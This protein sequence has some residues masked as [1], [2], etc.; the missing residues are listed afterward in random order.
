MSHSLRPLPFTWHQLGK[1]PFIWKALSPERK[2]IGIIKIES[3]AEDLFIHGYL[4]IDDDTIVLLMD[5]YVS[6]Y[7]MPR[8]F[9]T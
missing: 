3:C 9:I 1:E 5:L 8:V 7:D 4:K 6:Y 2:H